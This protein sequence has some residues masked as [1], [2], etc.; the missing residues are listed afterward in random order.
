MD[1]SEE[2]KECSDGENLTDTD[3]HSNTCLVLIISSTKQ[4]LGFLKQ[5]HSSVCK[6]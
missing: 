6:L 2:V 4:A 3:T 1:N 5:E